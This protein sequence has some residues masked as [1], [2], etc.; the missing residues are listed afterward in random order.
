MALE[1]KRNDC[2][3]ELSRRLSPSTR[4]IISCENKF[5]FDEKIKMNVIKARNAELKSDYGP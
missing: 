1:F 5:L 4:R 3:V 2:I